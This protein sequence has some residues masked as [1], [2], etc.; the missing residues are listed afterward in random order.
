MLDPKNEFR[1]DISGLGFSV[2]GLGNQGLG[3][4]RLGTSRLQH[5]RNRNR[6]PVNS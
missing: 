2:W 1:L 5:P 3:S 6:K 4:G